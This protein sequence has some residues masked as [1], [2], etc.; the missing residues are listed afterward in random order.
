MT[1]LLIT[2]KKFADDRGWFSETYSVAGFADRGISTVFCQD[3]HSLSVKPGTLRGIHFQNLPDAQAK[4]V[5]CTRGRIYDVAVDLRPDSPTFAKWVA[6]EL[7]ADNGQQL[8]VPAGYGH[9]FLTLEEHSEVQY[10]VDA[11]YAPQSDAGVR[12]DDP[13]LAIDW[14][15]A[16]YALPPLTLSEKDAQLPLVS[17]IQLAFPYDGRPLLPLN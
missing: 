5:R 2:P 13:L 3:N 12:W 17:D 9:A 16:D 7:S 11:Y 14:P 1:A 10:K 6:A 8:F 4:L 15:F